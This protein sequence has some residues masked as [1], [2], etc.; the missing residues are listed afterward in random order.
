M[1]P[2]F[3]PIMA[4]SVVSDR[5]SGSMLIVNGSSD[6]LFAAEVLLRRLYGH[7]PE[8]KPNLL[9]AS[10]AGRT[11]FVNTRSFSQLVA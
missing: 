4:A 10:H 1:I 8:Q 7:M 11:V 6:A 3:N 2:L 5:S 9:C